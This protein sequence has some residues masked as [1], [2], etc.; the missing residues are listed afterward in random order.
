MKEFGKKI[1]EA[2]NW[3]QRNCRAALLINCG[4]FNKGSKKSKNNPK[5]SGCIEA[6]LRE[7]YNRKCH[8]N[9]DFKVIA[10]NGKGQN[11]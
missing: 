6:Q 4:V 1:E 7:H 3:K 5:K 2:H 8:G 9:L 10:V 11:L